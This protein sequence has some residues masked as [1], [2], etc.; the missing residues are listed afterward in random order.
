MRVICF[1]AG[2]LF[3]NH[4]IVFG[5]EGSVLIDCGGPPSVILKK[6]A[7]AGA[8]LK[9]ILLTHAHADHIA[10]LDGVTEKLSVPVYLHPLDE[11][12]L[13]DASKNQSGLIYRDPVFSRVKFSPVSD[14]QILEIADLSFRVI[15]TPGHTPGS[16]CYLCGSAIF[17]GDTLFR[18]SIGGDFPPYGDLQTEIRSI[19]EG[20]FCLENDY[21]CFPGHG[22][23]T[24]LDHERKNNPFL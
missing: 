1:S 12:L 20:L 10:G 3:T 18:E 9:A 4:Y 8:E 23:R 13:R 16:V 21:D 17:T 11:P 7:E 15:H 5:N 19:R 24:T 2:R 22:E 6:L 14:G